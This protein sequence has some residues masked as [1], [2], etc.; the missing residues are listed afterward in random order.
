MDN[1]LRAEVFIH[2][3]E[4]IPRG[5][6]K[7]EVVRKGKVVSTETMPNTVLPPP[8]VIGCPNGDPTCFTCS[9]NG[10]H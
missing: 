7:V 3:P 9:T 10:G 2:G 5:T 4:V 6:L 8:I 1:P